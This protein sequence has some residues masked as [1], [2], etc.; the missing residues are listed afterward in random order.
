[1]I[2]IVSRHRLFHEQ[3]SRLPSVEKRIKNESKC[4]AHVVPVLLDDKALLQL[5]L[6][7]D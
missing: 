6:A 3:R 1:M 2:S 4:Q 7:F 5:Y